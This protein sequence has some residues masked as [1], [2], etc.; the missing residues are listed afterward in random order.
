MLSTANSKDRRS[1]CID[2]IGA[3]A[4]DLLARYTIPSPVWKSSYRLV[5][6]KEGAPMLEGWAIVDNT[7]GEDW[8]GVHLSVVS[9]K[10]ISFITQLYPPRYITRPEV[11]LAENRAVAPVVFQGAMDAISAAAPAPPAAAKAMRAGGGGGMG[12]KDYRQNVQ[13]ESSVAQTAQGSDAGELF[14]YSFAS[15]VTVKKG[16]SAMLPFLQQKIE[17]RK[18]LIYSESFGLNAM[19]AAEITNNTGKTLDG[20]P[21]TVYD[22]NTYAG[23]ALVETV[24]A[25]DKREADQLRR[26][27]RHAPHHHAIRFL[28]R[29]GPRNS[30]PPRRFNRPVGH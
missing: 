27:S 1:I 22:A 18:L 8:T 25:G 9:G 7:S 12:G 24:K 14:E 20:G 13:V 10:P 11:E 28:P 17:T 29:R 4:R 23:E 30:F 2:S 21:I 19:N 15:P 3:A 26:R 5:F 16:E 6:G